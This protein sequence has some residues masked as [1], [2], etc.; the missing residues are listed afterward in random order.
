MFK[1]A[2]IISYVL[3]LLGGAIS[4]LSMV[5]TD[6]Q[7]LA[8][9]DVF[10]SFASVRSLLIFAAV[11]EL[12]VVAG[13]VLK[14]HLFNPFVAVAWFSIILVVYRT[15]YA[16][17]GGRNICSCMGNI[18][19]ILGISPAAAKVGSLMLLGYLLLSSLGLLA[20][21]YVSRYRRSSGQG[22]PLT[23]LQTTQEN[24]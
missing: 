23:P 17:S 12:A 4:K 5:F 9:A 13:I 20:F 18:P 16:M 2:I 8:Q 19:Q 15:G 7:F 1:K 3:I 10:F 6:F 22:R 11:I 24:T 21:E 14:P